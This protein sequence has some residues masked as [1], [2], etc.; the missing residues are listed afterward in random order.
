MFRSLEIRWC[1][2]INQKNPT[3]VLLPLDEF[4]AEKNRRVYLSTSFKRIPHYKTKLISLL[5]LE[6]HLRHGFQI[7]LRFKDLKWWDILTNGSIDMSQSLRA[8]GSYFLTYF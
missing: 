1:L 8:G 4:F 6:K 5:L 2:D 7:I 3:T